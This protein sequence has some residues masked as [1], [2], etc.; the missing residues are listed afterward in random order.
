SMA[1]RSTSRAASTGSVPAVP[2]PP[3]SVSSMMTPR[4][5]RMLLCKLREQHVV[6]VL[7]GL[8]RRRAAN[9]LASSRPAIAACRSGAL[10]CLAK[11]MI[12]HDGEAANVIKN[13][14]GCHAACIDHRPRRPRAEL[15]PSEAGLDTLTN[16]EFAAIG[17]A[18]PDRAAALGAERHP[19][20]GL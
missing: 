1:A 20:T 15:H 13:R 18:E 11:V 19:R 8:F 5:S 4:S 3:V 14:K 17:T 9:G 16:R 6:E 10:A 7:T 12:N 2:A